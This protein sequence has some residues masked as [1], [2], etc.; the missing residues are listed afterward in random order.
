MPEGTRAIGSAKHRAASRFAVAARDAEVDDDL[1]AAFAGLA[2]VM[3][4][5]F[6]CHNAYRGIEV[7]GRCPSKV[8]K[9]QE[10]VS[11]GEA[12]GR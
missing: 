9:G 12:R 10:R 7:R 1:D 5:C 11:S 8:Y 6:A 2:E 4:Q 3:V